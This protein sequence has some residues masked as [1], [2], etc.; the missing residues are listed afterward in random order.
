M[1]GRWIPVIWAAGFGIVV[2]GLVIWVLSP[3]RRESPDIELRS[4]SGFDAAAVAPDGKYVLAGG[5]KNVLV[6][7]NVATG[8]EVRQYGF[9]KNGPTQEIWQ[10]AFSPDGNY[11][12]AA[13]QDRDLCMWR[14]DTGEQ[15]RV[16][17]GHGN[18]ALSFAVTPD[19]ARVIT[20][21]NNRHLRLWETG[22]GKRLKEARFSGTQ[23]VSI[24]LSGDGQKFLV[25]DPYEVLLWDLECF[26]QV[27]QFK[28]DE[29]K[30][31]ITS[32]VFSP[33]DKRFLTSSWDG[34][35]REWNIE[36]GQETHE[37]QVHAGKVFN[38]SLNKMGNRLIAGGDSVVAYMA[39][40][41]GAVLR[42]LR[43]RRRAWLSPDGTFAVIVGDESRLLIW[44]L[45]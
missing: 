12:F 7:W 4:S 2:T 34:T 39:Y 26:Q 22:S 15:V 5:R 36:T 13:G 3:T 6:L 35:V 11:V 1:M 30:R 28:C 31:A 24:A 29:H 9:S 44:R 14:T 32:A 43:G 18:G 38:V 25:C 20:A 45:K 16:F 37:Y 21:D 33:D 17:P 10:V 42:S 41:S 40:P 27:R 19:G 23:A 8:K